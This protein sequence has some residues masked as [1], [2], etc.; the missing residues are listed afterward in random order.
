VGALMGAPPLGWA[1]G[2]IRVGVNQ[3][4]VIGKAPKSLPRSSDVIGCHTWTAILSVK[5]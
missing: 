3:P 4:G 1:A 2:F 5:Y